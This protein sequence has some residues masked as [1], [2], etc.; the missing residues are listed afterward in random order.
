MINPY[1]NPEK[2]G[3]EILGEADL[4]S[5]NWEFDIIC[6]WVNRQTNQ[7]YYAEDSGCS[8]PSPFENHGFGDDS[9]SS[10]TIVPMT[11]HEVISHIQMRLTEN[12]KDN[13]NEK[14]GIESGTNLISKVMSL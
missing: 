3:L 4:S 5:G 8:C 9:S 7:L 6:V 14:C 11:P 1:D 10:K 2:L 12:A 13:W